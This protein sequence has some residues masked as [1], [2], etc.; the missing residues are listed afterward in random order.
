MQRIC[1]I[2]KIYARPSK[3]FVAI[4]C[5]VY[6]GKEKNWV[7]WLMID[8]YHDETEAVRVVRLVR[9]LLTAN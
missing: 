4:D 6:R 5:A 7:Q 8:W 1:L 9:G 3:F 2:I